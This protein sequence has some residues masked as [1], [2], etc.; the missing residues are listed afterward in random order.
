MM[1]EVFGYTN[2]GDVIHSYTLENKNN[3]KV[4]ILSYGAIVQSVLVPDK[5]GVVRDIVL[6]YDDLDG[7][8]KNDCYMGAVV[9]RNANRIA[10]ARCNINGVTYELEK[11]D[12]EN[13]LHSGKNTFSKK[14]WNLKTE[15]TE[16]EQ[17]HE[18][19]VTLIYTSKEFDQGFP[20]NMA[21]EVTYTLNDKNELMMEYAAKADCQTIANFTNHSYFNLAGQGV[22]GIENHKLKIYSSQYTP[23]SDKGCIP[24]GTLADVAG[25]PMDFSEEKKIGKDINEEFDQ[26]KFV[27]GYDHN[28]VLDNTDKNE[29]VILAASADCDDTGIMLELF[30]DCDGMQ[31]YTG[32]GIH[33]HLGKNG[34]IYHS[35]SGFCLETQ[36]FP[37]AINHPEFRAPLTDKEGEYHA[38]SIYR[39]TVK[40]I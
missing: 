40:Q 14:I 7:Y 23:I 38:K 15:K 31:F 12:G 4:K 29:Q 30:T 11:N 34:V 13:N 39:F 10:N 8:L 6:G 20:G 32:N 33:D 25:T 9:G 37:D 3:M 35:R 5:N 21:A 22:A 26:L 17:K 36:C 2:G 1:T 27:G 28:Y 19:S 18:D 16:N 24:V